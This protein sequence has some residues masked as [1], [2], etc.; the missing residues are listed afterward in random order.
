MGDL[1]TKWVTR[2]AARLPMAAVPV[3]PGC[4]SAAVLVATTLEQITARGCFVQR[5]EAG[6]TDFETLWS[7][8]LTSADGETVRL[9]LDN[10]AAIAVASAVSTRLIER[11]L[12]RSLTLE[13]RALVDY[14]ALRVADTLAQLSLLRGWSISALDGPRE[15]LPGGACVLSVA[16]GGV[17]GRARISGPLGSIADFAPLI[18]QELDEPIGI[19]LGIG[20]CEVSAEEADRL[21]PGDTILLGATLLDRLP[22]VRL[23]SRS[24]WTLA[25][26]AIERHS[27]SSISLSLCNWRVAASRTA[28]EGAVRLSVEL[29]DATLARKDSG[30]P[31]KLDIPAGP[32]APVRVRNGRGSSAP[33]ELVRIDDEIAVRLIGPF[34]PSAHTET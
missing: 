20:E 18:L 10:A 1:R 4:L 6:R 16:I 8:D 17:E 21:A 2:I 12:S 28:P 33:G 25:D 15:P 34:A 23:V 11:L 32:D 22:G 31:V 30:L 29:G 27:E 7:T 26:A 9:E 13:E 14:A 3:P 5:L 24:G 19:A